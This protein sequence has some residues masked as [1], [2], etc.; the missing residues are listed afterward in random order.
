M[1]K[2]MPVWA[3]TLLLPVIAVVMYRMLE[4]LIFSGAVGLLVVLLPSFLSLWM[5]CGYF[6]AQERRSVWQAVLIAYSPMLIMLL[7]LTALWFYQEPENLYVFRNTILLPWFE[8]VDFSVVVP[9]G[10]F[11][12][13]AVSMETVTIVS[14]FFVALLI[15]LTAFVGSAHY[16][17]GHKRLGILLILG[18]ALF[19]LVIKA[20]SE[21]GYYW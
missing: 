6:L 14:Q 9:I 13:W 3:K 11:I 5:V 1:L 12:S 18:L 21:W 7:A 15:S 16:A 2:K 10:V 4:D 20:K 19:I 17:L 8:L